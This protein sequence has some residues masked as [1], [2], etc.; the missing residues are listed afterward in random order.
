MP[1]DN[2]TIQT[3][4]KTGGNTPVDEPITDIKA[5]MTAGVESRIDDTEDRLD[6]LEN[7][8]MITTIDLNDEAGADYQITAA[9]QTI[10]LTDNYSEEFDIILPVATKGLKIMVS[11][12]HTESVDVAPTGTD[13]IN[14]VN[15]AISIATTV[16]STFLCYANGAWAVI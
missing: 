15:N 14:L 1:N 10:V 6:D 7:A 8:N 12:Q 2:C 11:N 13:T 5:Y 3:R 4:D 16:S 9:S